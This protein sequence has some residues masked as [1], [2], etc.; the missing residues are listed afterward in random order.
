MAFSNKY[1]KIYLLLAILVGVIQTAT[2]GAGSSVEAFTHK[3]IS[4]TDLTFKGSKILIKVTAKIQLRSP[5]DMSGDLLTNMG[6][7]LADCSGTG[8]NIKLL[9]VETTARGIFFFN[10]QYAEQ[11]WFNA[12]DGQANRR[13]RWRKGSDPWIKTYCWAGKGV[14]RQRIRPGSPDENKQSPI[15][16]TQRSESFYPY[17]KD[18]T[19]CP[20]VSEPTFVFYFLSNL[21]PSKLHTPFE[22]CVFGKKQL[23]RLTFRYEELD[24]SRVTVT[25]SS[26]V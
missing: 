3:D 12:A 22:I 20:V 13:I 24:P 14:R 18:I 9:A 4:W 1:T 5:A 25:P 21:D 23:H 26:T 10:E 8:E 7:G 19:G 16:W 11:V 15:K 6:A 2:A 17:P